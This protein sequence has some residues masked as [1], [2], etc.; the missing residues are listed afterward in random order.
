MDDPFLEVDVT[1]V[2][3]GEVSD[4]RD[5]RDQ[6]RQAVG[7]NRTAGSDGT[8]VTEGNEGADDAVELVTQPAPD[9]LL[10]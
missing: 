3:A 10:R 2:Q 1:P 9:A 5:P 6:P 8:N 4:P 7:W